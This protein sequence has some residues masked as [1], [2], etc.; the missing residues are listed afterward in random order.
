MT[1]RIILLLLLSV[2]AALPLCAQVGDRVDRGP[3]VARFQDARA[4][5]AGPQGLLYVADAGIDALV[6]LGPQ[7][8]LRME[9]GGAG[10]GPGGFFDPSD[11]D[12][13]NGLVLVVADAGNHRIQRFTSEFRPLEQL[14]VDPEA[15]LDRGRPVSVVAAPSGALYAI[16]AATGSIIKWDAGR[17][18]AWVRGG[19]SDLPAR[20]RR[21]VSLALSEEWLYVADQVLGAVLVYD[22]F[23]NYGY[24]IAVGPDPRAL[25]LYRNVLHL[26]LPQA[27][28][29][30]TPQG[31]RIDTITFG[32]GPALVDAAVSGEHLWLLT[33]KELT[34]AV[35]PTLPAA[36]R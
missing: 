15:G 11:V 7:R 14:A 1:A 31:R 28:V 35:Y 5:A 32:S 24:S 26:V 9:L 33:E 3:V 21:P 36:H 19:A 23:G 13:T 29:R 25:F 16:D 20:A 8:G 2:S 10:Y 34:A 22:H 17:D 4:L 27:V 12:P 18:V 30:L 6:R